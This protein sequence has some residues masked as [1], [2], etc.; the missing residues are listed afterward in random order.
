MSK[1]KNAAAH[2]LF[3]A[4]STDGT[5]WIFMIVSGES[6][7]ITRNGIEVAAGAT[8]RASLVSGVEKFLTLTRNVVV[9]EDAPRDRAVQAQLDRIERGTPVASSVAKP[10]RGHKVARALQEGRP[11]PLAMSRRGDESS[12]AAGGSSARAVF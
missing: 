9:V 2:P 7:G 5:D 6:W 3:R 8:G 1:G 12:C 4:V 11:R 10:R